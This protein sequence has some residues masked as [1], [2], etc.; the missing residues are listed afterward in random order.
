MPGFASYFT[1]LFCYSFDIS[2]LCIKASTYGS[3]AHVHG[4]NFVNSMLDAF[5]ATADRGGIGAHFLTQG[6]RYSILQV[7]AA[8]LQNILVFYG[9]CFKLRSKAVKGLQQSFALVAD[10]DLNRG[11]K[12]IVGGL[13]HIAMVIRRNNIVAAFRLTG[14]LQG[15]VAKDLVHIHVNRG[16]STALDRINREL[17]QHLAGNNLIC[18]SD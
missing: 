12:Y 16:T 11:W 13:G 9:L 8:H 6:N 14:K 17:V 1:E 4:M 10:A 5:H 15:P 18:S 2:W 3:T 7:S